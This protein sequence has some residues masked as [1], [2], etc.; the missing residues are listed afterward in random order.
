MAKIIHPIA[1][2]VALLLIFT[3]WSTTIGVELF[4]T[5][6]QVIAVK[7]AIPWG[8]LLLIPAMAVT[9]G[10][11]AIRSRGRTGGLVG[12]K[13]RRM[14][15]A[16]ANGI[17]VL[18]PAALFLSRQAAAGDFGW[19]FQTVQAVELIAGTVNLALI[20][21]NMRDGLRMSGRLRRRSRGKS[22]G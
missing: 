13:T 12:R 6:R 18:I 3:F 17:L 16:A 11:G 20:G 7:Q 10:T 1:G 14:Q 2:A 19:A 4:G 8:F 15:Y 21:L 22:V 5:T 9:G